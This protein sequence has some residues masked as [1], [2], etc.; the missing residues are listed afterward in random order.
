VVIKFYINKS[1]VLRY[2]KYS[3]EEVDKITNDLINECIEEIKA[4]KNAN[5]VFNIFDISKS[6]NKIYVE[7]S[8]LIFRGKDIYNHLKSSEK[9]AIMASTLGSGIDKKIRYYSK[10]DLT[11]SI[12]MDAC[13]TAAIESLCDETEKIIKKIAAQ[14]GFNITFRYSPGYGDFSIDIQ[15]EIIK[16]LNA[17]RQIGLTV[18]N[19]YML[20]PRK[21]VTAVIGFCRNEVS[22]KSM[23][24]R[25]CS[26]YKNCVYVKKGDQCG[27]KRTN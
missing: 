23:G 2:L 12:V 10:V 8:T 16:V 17:H 3:G 5:F 1:E 4:D 25:D 14:E 9:C 7:D 15:P 21:S 19:N 18:T 24:C 13:A 20:V 22:S 11:K 6:H 26:S 27:L